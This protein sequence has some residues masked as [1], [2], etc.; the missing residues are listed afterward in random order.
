[1]KQDSR[2]SLSWIFLWPALVVPLLGSLLYFVWLPGAAWAQAVYGLTKLFTLVYP[3]FFVGWKELLKQ[4]PTVSWKAVIVWGLGSGVAICAAGALLMLSPVGD[5]V[6]EGAGPIREKAEQLGFVSNFLLFA[7]FISI[8]HSAL[9]EF[10]WRGFVFGKLREKTGRVVAHVGAGIAFAAHHLVVTW[11]YFD[12]PLAI[13]LALFVAIGGVIWTFLYQRQGSLI[14]C[15]LS[16]LC[17]DVFLMV[18]GYQLMF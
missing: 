10:Y 9:E 18:V 1:M 15:W 5:M 14:G 17:V 12:P 6:R 8:F 16:H 2:R 4:A 13:V 3:F 11:Q 7:V